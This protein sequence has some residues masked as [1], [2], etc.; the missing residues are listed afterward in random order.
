MKCPK[1]EYLDI[2]FNRLEKVNE[3]WAGHPSIKVFKSV[4]NKFKNLA[5]F[6]ELP[7]LEELYLA[8]NVIT[9]LSGWE[10]LPALRKLH[11]RKNKIEKL[12]DELPPLDSLKYINL[13]GNKIPNLEHLQ[14]LF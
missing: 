3:A 10:N 6:K 9:S 14:K 4:D 11:L 1:L 13:R 8:S 2:S 7:K 5:P 12:D